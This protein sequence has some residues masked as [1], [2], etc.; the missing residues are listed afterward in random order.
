MKASLYRCLLQKWLKWNRASY[1]VM[2]SDTG[3]YLMVSFAYDHN[4]GW[5]KGMKQF[6]PA[7]SVEHEE[8]PVRYSSSEVNHLSPRE[9]TTMLQTDSAG[10]YIQPGRRRNRYAC[11]KVLWG[12]QYLLCFSCVTDQLLS[13]GRA[14]FKKLILSHFC[15]SD[16]LAIKLGHSLLKIMD[17]FCLFTWK[18]GFIGVIETLKDEQE[19]YSKPY[20]IYHIN[21]VY[22][23]NIPPELI[24]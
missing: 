23:V 14:L 22:I 17:I 13:K 1:I 10:N 11:R 19:R 6:L 16:V 15:V 21:L 9:V 4:E 2:I 7:K 24:F 3:F 12:L 20:C 8:T 18:F 5:W